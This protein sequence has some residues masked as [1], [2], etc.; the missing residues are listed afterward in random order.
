M[1]FSKAEVTGLKFSQLV[2]STK[3]KLKTALGIDETVTTKVFTKPQRDLLN[4]LWIDVTGREA[5]LGAF[6]K[7]MPDWCRFVATRTVSGKFVVSIDVFSD[8]VT[9]PYWSVLKECPIIELP[10]SEFD[11]PVA[12]IE[13]PIEVK[14]K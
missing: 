12:P 11:F 2:K 1:T 13:T 14:S 8:Q 3:D 6:D 4:T 10:S 9:K 5:E 7:D